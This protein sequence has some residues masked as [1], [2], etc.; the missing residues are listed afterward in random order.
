MP[1]VASELIESMTMEKFRSLAILASATLVLS[2]CAAIYQVNTVPGTCDG[3]LVSITATP[4]NPTA[5][6]I[7]EVDNQ[8]DILTITVHGNLAD[9]NL[10]YAIGLYNETGLGMIDESLL[11]EDSIE[12][13]PPATVPSFFNIGDDLGADA[14]LFLDETVFTEVSDDR[15][16]A[17][18]T[19][20]DFFVGGTVLGDPWESS[21]EIALATL[22][23][24]GAFLIQCNKTGASE[25]GHIVGVSQ[26]FPNLV[27]FDEEDLPSLSADGDSIELFL[28]VEYAGW[29]VEMLGN[30][31]TD[32]EPFSEDLATDRW[33]QAFSVDGENPDEYFSITGEVG[34]SGEVNVVNFFG[35]FV[36][37]ATYN[38]LMVIY[39]PVFDAESDSVPLK[40]AVFDV[41]INNSGEAVFIPFEG[42]YIPV[43]VPSRGYQSPEISNAITS[44]TV[45]A[46]G[47]RRL[48]INGKALE[49]VTAA[50]VGTLA[51]KVI[52]AEES[53]LTLQVPKLKPGLYPLTLTHSN[54]DVVISDF[55]RVR[56]SM[57]LD[58]KRIP[59]K[60]K[61]K[62]WGPVVS[63]MVTGGS[64]GVQLDCVALVPEGSKTKPIKRKAKAICDSVQSAGITKRVAV[65][66]VASGKAPA[67][68]LNLW[69]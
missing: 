39:G 52:S 29:D 27:V 18:G 26:M 16:V 62:Q 34:D 30:L 51:A 42:E 13:R 8:D 49:K 54:G 46:K 36:P 6:D 5:G 31:R 38:F 17:E 28:P 7:S 3:D 10:A 68:L 55:V 1:L 32:S 14:F 33:L 20:I 65:R 67:I 12:S 23:M 21:Y 45:S 19:L 11:A 9:L 48:V 25:E 56:Q 40:T 60:F 57:K 59:L 4:Q 47:D 15:W 43:R 22:L 58:S 69:D 50:K 53:A 35:N 37:N 61:I 41:R 66:P 2:G 63:G 24:P 44:T 64:N